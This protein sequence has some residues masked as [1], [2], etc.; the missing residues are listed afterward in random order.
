MSINTKKHEDHTLS[1]PHPDCFITNTTE[2]PNLP[3]VGCELTLQTLYVECGSWQKAE[4]KS[5][6]NGSWSHPNHPHPHCFDKTRFLRLFGIS[7][8]KELK[9]NLFPKS[10]RIP[11][12]LPIT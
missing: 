9:K 6:D 2:R 8:E 10:G 12:E 5:I 11:V 3:L 7:S 1:M 4:M